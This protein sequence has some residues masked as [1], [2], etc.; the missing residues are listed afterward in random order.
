MEKYCDLLGDKSLYGLASRHFDWF[1]R[2]MRSGCVTKFSRIRN[3]RRTCK[4]LYYSQVLGGVGWIHVMVEKW[5]SRKDYG[6]PE[7][8]FLSNIYQKRNRNKKN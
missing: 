3:L 5:K 1:M 2:F 7:G 4:R 8:T 6:T